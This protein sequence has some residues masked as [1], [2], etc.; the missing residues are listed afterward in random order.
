MWLL[1]NLQYRNM[2]YNSLSSKIPSEV[3]LLLSLKWISLQSNN[4]MSGKILVKFCNFVNGYSHL[5]NT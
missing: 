3:G 1:S 2:L 4:Q 5:F